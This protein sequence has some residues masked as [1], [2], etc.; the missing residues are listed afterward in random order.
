MQARPGEVRGLD[1][2]PNAP[3]L[4]PPPC[5]VLLRLSLGFSICRVRRS[6]WNLVWTLVQPQCQGTSL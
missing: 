5:L 4:L 2:G 3:F 6:N 1:F